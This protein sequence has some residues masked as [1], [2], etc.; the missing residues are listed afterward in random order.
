MIIGF[1][2]GFRQSWDCATGVVATPVIED[3][4]KAWSRRPLRGS[5][6]RFRE[7]SSAR[8]RSI[9]RDPVADRHRP[10]GAAAVRSWSRPPH[11]EGKALFDRNPLDDGKKNGGREENADPPREEPEEL[12]EVTS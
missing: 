6:S 12:E 1:D 8:T 4:T 2:E 9:D 5:A 11:M 3:N 7:C 10:H